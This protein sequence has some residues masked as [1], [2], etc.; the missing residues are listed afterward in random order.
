MLSDT[1]CETFTNRPDTFLADLLKL[2][3]DSPLSGFSCCCLIPAQQKTFQQSRWLLSF[4]WEVSTL[5]KQTQTTLLFPVQRLMKMFSDTLW[6]FWGFSVLCYFMLF[7]N[8]I[9]AT[10]SLWSGTVRW[11]SA[12]PDWQLWV[13]VALQAVRQL[14]CHDRLLLL[15]E[16][17]T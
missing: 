5:L 11:A 3:T 10:T 8:L 1:H 14:C 15:S 7:L 2:L 13:N 16:K 12:A 6:L 9:H 17:R 4:Q